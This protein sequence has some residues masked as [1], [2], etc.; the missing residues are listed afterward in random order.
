MLKEKTA[1]SIRIKTSGYLSFKEHLFKEQA[2]EI[3]GQ[4]IKNT[5]L[6]KMYLEYAKNNGFEDC[7][8]QCTFIKLVR[9]DAKF[10]KWQ[11]KKIRG[12][13]GDFTMFENSKKLQK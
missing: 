7:Y 12:N 9:R 5:E 3:E 4:K 10:Y 2:D 13:R 11:A 1:K 8:P 6:Y